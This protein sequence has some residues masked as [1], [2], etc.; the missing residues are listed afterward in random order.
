MKC[1]SANQEI[2][3]NNIEAQEKS[4]FLILT[5]D[6]QKIYGLEVTRILQPQ[7]LRRDLLIGI[8]EGQKALLVH[9]NQYILGLKKSH[10]D[11]DNVQYLLALALVFPLASSLPPF[12]C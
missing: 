2:V 11:T 1:W 4:C 8:L 6:E 3:Q 10:T 7:I 5:L 12:I 9:T